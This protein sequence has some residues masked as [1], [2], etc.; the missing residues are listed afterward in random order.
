MLD[1]TDDFQVQNLLDWRSIIEHLFP[2]SV[3]MH[4][5]WE[6]R[7]SIVSILNEVSHAAVQ[8]DMHLPD[9][10]GFMLTGAK[11]AN[12]DACIELQ[13]E[14]RPPFIVKSK[15]L[16]FQSFGNDYNWAYFL[17]ETNEL[18]VKYG[19]VNNNLKELL[20]E[21]EPGHYINYREQDDFDYED[22]DDEETSLL[23]NSRLLCRYLSG[24][25]M[26]VPKATPYHQVPHN[27]SG[28]HN[29]MDKDAFKTWIE[30]IINM[31]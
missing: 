12:E 29:T 6:G 13:W 1:P 22:R 27:R 23:L 28:I 17:L 10:G 5:I 20:R 11:I 19:V 14:H 30:T 16:I 18:D 8:N 9:S 7:E 25:F 4:C 2:I 24:S 3:P 15:R 26:L 21:I 31:Q